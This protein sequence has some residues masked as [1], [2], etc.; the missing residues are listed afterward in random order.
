[1]KAMAFD[2]A[3]NIDYSKVQFQEQRI[4]GKSNAKYKNL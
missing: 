2:Y 4:G 1:M 3:E